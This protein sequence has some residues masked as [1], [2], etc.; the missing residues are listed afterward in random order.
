M[1]YHLLFRSLIT[2]FA[3]KG[4]G[5]PFYYGGN[6]YW[7]RAGELSLFLFSAIVTS[8]GEPFR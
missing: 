6:C 2:G 4:A 3:R 1:L 8:R 5:W 7:F